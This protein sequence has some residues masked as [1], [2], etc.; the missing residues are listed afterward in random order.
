MSYEIQKKKKKPG[1]TTLI[2]T[3]ADSHIQ[4][5]AARLSI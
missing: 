5:M 4:G 2:I 3:V 1:F